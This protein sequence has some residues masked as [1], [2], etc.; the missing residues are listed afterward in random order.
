MNIDTIRSWSLVLPALL[1]AHSVF[2]ATEFSEN[3]DT[4]SLPATLEESSCCASVSVATGAAVFPGVGNS[5]RVF[6]RSVE[7]DFHATS[8]VIE[9]TVTLANGFAGP[10]TA[11][12]GLGRGDPLPSF[13]GEPRDGPHLFARFF[14]NDI[15]NGIISVVDDGIDDFSSAAGTAG[16][17]THRIRMTWNA[18]TEE[19]IFQIH[20]NYTGGTFVASTTTDPVDGSNNG[21]T[22]TDSRIFFGAASGV[23]FDDLSVVFLNTDDLFADSFEDSVP[24]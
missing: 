11:F 2:G 20:Q 15:G 12:V 21:F 14:P 7:D 18:E 23:T 4:M 5:Q 22:A 3:F 8:F 13:Y 6:L 1:L 10:G 19:A 9:I 16:A 24:D 17:G